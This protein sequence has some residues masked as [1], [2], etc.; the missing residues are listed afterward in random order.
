MTPSSGAASLIALMACGT[1]PSGS[2]APV[3]VASLRAG[4]MFGNRA[5]AGMPSLTASFAA[6]AAAFGDSRSTPG[7][8]GTPTR[9]SAPSCRI[10][11]QMKSAGVSTCSATSRRIHEAW[12]RRRGRRAGKGAGDGKLMKL[13]RLQT[14]GGPL[15]AQPDHADDRG[16]DQPQAG[17]RVGGQKYDQPDE[18]H[19]R[20]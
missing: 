6:S 17:Y 13:A 8:D 16:H 4:S 2:L 12:R 1:S 10:S 19:R 5:T 7:I 14:A 3:P 15:G 11:G 20:E 9:S 18:E